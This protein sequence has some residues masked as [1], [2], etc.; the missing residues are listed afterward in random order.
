MDIFIHLSHSLDTS[1]GFD[2]VEFIGKELFEIADY[3][4]PNSSA[5]SIEFNSVGFIG[6]ELFKIVVCY[7]Q[8]LKCFGLDGTLSK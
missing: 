5:T 7:Q 6:K 4:V 3:D 8:K 2:S 1:I